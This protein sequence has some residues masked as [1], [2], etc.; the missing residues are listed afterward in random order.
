MT[1]VAYTREVSPTLADCELTHLERE[2]LDVARAAAE[3]HAYEELLSQLGATVRRLP[4]APALPDAVF[5][6]DTAV[7]LDEIAVIT[8][9]GAVSRRPETPSVASALAAHRPLA[10]IEGP[11]T[12]DGG[13]VQAFLAETVQ[14]VSAHPRITVHL[15]T[16]AANVD[17]H[18]GD[19]TSTLATTDCDAAEP[20][21]R[22]VEHGVVVVATGATEQKVQR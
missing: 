2:P 20:A 12:L 19:F 14:R 16:H 11:A 22:R 3:H 18:I 21:E 5:V 15:K 4:A 1:L 17:G 6:E 10:Q 8:R 9:P 13:D 7:V